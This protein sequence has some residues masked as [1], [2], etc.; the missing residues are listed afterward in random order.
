MAGC[1]LSVYL[2]GY[3][4]RFVNQVWEPF[5]GD[6]SQHI[7]RSA[8]SD[9]LPIPDAALGAAGYLVEFALLLIGGAQRW[10]TLPW[11]VLCYG[12]VMGL[13]GVGSMVLVALQILIFRE[14]C[15]LCLASAAISLTIVVLGFDEPLASLRHIS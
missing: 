2:A 7:L 1:V 13:L 8:F 11:I 12:G 3:Q 15:T 9:A 10:R 4:L 6:G 14:F 5:F